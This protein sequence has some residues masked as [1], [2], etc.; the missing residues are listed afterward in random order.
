M[1]LAISHEFVQL[2]GGKLE[3]ESTLGKGSVFNFNVIVRLLETTQNSDCTVQTSAVDLL[4]N[5]QQNH[6]TKEITEEITI[7]NLQIMSR[8]WIANLNQAAIEV[9][10]D[11]IFKLIEQIPN[12]YQLLAEEIT[13][14]IR[15]YDF[16]AI[17]ALSRE[18]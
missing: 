8:E 13:K 1:G 7:E 17:I 11:R 12:Q 10:A 16:D 15:N 4:E 18:E 3:V 6:L 9:D 14:L 5:S 2:M